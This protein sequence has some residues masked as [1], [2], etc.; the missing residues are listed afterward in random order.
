MRMANIAGPMP[1]KVRKILQVN[2]AMNS[3]HGMFVCIRRIDKSSS[4]F[5]QFFVTKSIT[6]SY[7][8]FHF[9]L[10]IKLPRKILGPSF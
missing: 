5:F 9:N 2:I 1:Q 6:I 7:F 8:I 3:K 4:V 10:E